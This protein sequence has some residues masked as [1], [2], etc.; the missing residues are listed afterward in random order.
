[1]AEFVATGLILIA[2]CGLASCVSDRELV[3]E[4]LAAR[5]YHDDR[6]RRE[7]VDATPAAQPPVTCEAFRVLVNDALREVTVCN[8]TQKIGKLPPTARRR[9]KALKKKMEAQP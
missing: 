6:Y 4:A 7:C 5:H 2:I 3:S 8:D 9:L 1:M